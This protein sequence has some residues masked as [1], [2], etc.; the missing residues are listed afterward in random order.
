MILQLGERIIYKATF[1][2]NMLKLI[3]PISKKDQVIAA[4]KEAI[5]SGAIGPG[6]QIVESRMAHELGS[7]IPLVR[8][9][10]VALEHQGFVQ[11]TPY[12]GTTVTKLEPRQ[13]QDNFQLRVE[14]EPLAVEWAKQNITP[15]DVRELRVLIERMERAAADLDLDKFYQNDLEWHRKLWA[16]S[17]NTYLEDV[18]ERLVVPLFA[19]FVMKTSRERE[20]Y[21]ESAD[22]HARIVDALADGSADEVRALMKESLS[23]WKTDM[24]TL[25]FSKP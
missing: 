1:S 4:I 8:E 12:K 23:G 11:K 10:L 16:L 9:A 5:L 20:A 18:L 24:M 6:D 15:G 22:M 7:G 2:R 3:Q 25:L 21:V 14:L 19:F 13:I 17:G